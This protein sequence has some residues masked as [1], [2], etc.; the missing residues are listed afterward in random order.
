MEDKDFYTLDDMF[1]ELIGSKL[2]W[3]Y[4]VL[5]WWCNLKGRI[6]ERIIKET[7]FYIDFAHGALF[8]SWD[9]EAYGD[10]G[11]VHIV[12]VCFHLWIWWDK[13]DYR[14]EI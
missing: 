12:F 11:E 13:R 3:R 2:P 10:H 5:I 1:P 8:F 6:R 14:E 4:R 9:I 7:D